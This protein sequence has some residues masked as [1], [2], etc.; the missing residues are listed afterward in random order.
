MRIA[1]YTSFASNYLA[2]A[3]VLANSIKAVNDGID[4]IA[5]VCDRLPS[6]LNPAA[7]PF[8]QIWMVDEYP[9]KLIKAW[10]FRHNIME[11][12]TAV[13]G[14]ALNRLLSM[15]YD[16]VLYLDPDCWVLADPAKIVELLKEHMSVLVV[17]HTT[18]PA[19]TKEAIRLVEV[20]SLKHGIYNLGF[21][22]VKNDENGKRFAKWWA[23]RLHDYCLIEFQHG[24]FTD[25]RWFDL[26]VGYFPFIQICWHKG[27]D[28]ASWNIGQRTISRSPSGG[29]LV[30]GDPLIFYHFSGVGPAGVHR[31]V[32]EIVAPSDPLAAELEFAYEELINA[33]GQGKLSHISPFYERYDDGR[34][35]ETADRANF[36]ASEKN[37]ELFPDPYM[38]GYGS[39]RESV[40]KK[41][42]TKNSAPV[43]EL[44]DA[45]IE[46]LAEKLFD[47]EFYGKYSSYAHRGAQRL[48]GSL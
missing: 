4:V 22:L 45:E 33:A 46:K 21:L 44:S 27:I 35:I 34:N 39:F 41:E 24:I 23:E 12:C 47:A 31:W 13:K 25:Q 38:T 10:I 28:L 29:Y 15:D 19:E 30:D 17:P 9:A 16:Y 2:K 48:V 36:R 7:E 20:S 8:N 40:M 5:I 43:R 18:S 1:V 26:A 42:I 14:W 11:L 3:R 6:N 37:M 32:R